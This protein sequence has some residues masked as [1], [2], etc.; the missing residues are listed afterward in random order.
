MTRAS[1]SFLEINLDALRSN[2]VTLRSKIPS[3]QK[4]M[5]VV[6]SDAYGHGASEVACALQKEGCQFFGVGTLDEAIQLRQSGISGTILMMLGVLETNDSYLSALAEHRLVPVVEDLPT[7]CLLND[8]AV[9]H[10]RCLPVHIKV[11]T[12]MGRLGFLV[13][14]GDEFL[15]KLTSLSSL[16]V[17]GLMSHLSDSGDRLYTE[18]QVHLFKTFVEKAALTGLRPELIHIASS[19]EALHYEPFG[20]LVRLGIALYTNPAD[21]MS[22]KSALISLRRVP[23]GASISYGRTFKTKRDSVIGTVPIGYADGYPRALSNK[24]LALV[25]GVK[26]PVIG[27]ICMDLLMLDVTDVTGVQVH[28]EVILMGKQGVG[29]I[30]SDE[31]AQRAG[32]ISYEIFCS[33]SKRLRR[34]YKENSL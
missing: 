4:I 15:K 7:A 14:R 12:G 23:K 3:H 8:W 6:K 24:G 18:E 21:V 34:C 1:P 29:Q 27:T 26:V 22:L 20:N 31:L 13:N 10:Q 9:K 11:D 2:F 17:T 33:L 19:V 25:R 30:R 32:T 28:D 5:A 16:H